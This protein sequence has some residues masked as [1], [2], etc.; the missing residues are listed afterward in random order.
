[1]GE[2]NVEIPSSVIN[3]YYLA[4]DSGTQVNQRTDDPY[5]P[6]TAPETDSLYYVRNSENDASSQVGAYTVLDN[7]IQEAEAHKHERYMVYDSAGIIVYTP[8]LNDYNLILIQE[9]FYDDKL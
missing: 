4:F 1:M 8:N 3:N 2:I 6:S 7:A 9:F 5:S